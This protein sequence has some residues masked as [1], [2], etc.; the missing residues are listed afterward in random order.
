MKNRAF[1]AARLAHKRY[2]FS[3]VYLKFRMLQNR[4]RITV[5][6]CKIV[7]GKHNLLVQRRFTTSGW[8]LV[9]SQ[10]LLHTLNTDNTSCR[11]HHIERKPHKCFHQLAQHKDERQQPANAQT[12]FHDKHHGIDRA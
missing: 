4:L 12:A 8:F 2:I 5:A 3:S 6:E 11:I 7:K 1:P 9:F 10:N